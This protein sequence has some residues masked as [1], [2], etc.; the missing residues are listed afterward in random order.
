M[1]KPDI[2]SDDE[3]IGS[4]ERRSQRCANQPQSGETKIS[5]R[6]YYNI[7][8]FIGKSLGKMMDMVNC[9]PFPA[10][11]AIARSSPAADRVR[12]DRVHGISVRGFEP[13]LSIGSRAFLASAVRERW[14]FSSTRLS[15]CGLIGEQTEQIKLFVAGPNMRGA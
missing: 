7:W 1:S 10:A 13:L 11:F 8:D 9:L 15:Q 14:R 6:V 12:P 3:K 5:I 2:R 4:D